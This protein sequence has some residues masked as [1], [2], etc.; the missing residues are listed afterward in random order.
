MST[1]THLKI[2]KRIQANSEISQRQL[3]QELGVSVGKVNYCLRALIDKGFVKAGNF[4]RSPNK[5][6]Y[7]Y[8]LTPTGIEEKASLTTRFLKRKIAEHEQITQEIE[9]LKRDVQSI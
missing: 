5:M 7:L 4:K 2:L 8:L 3:A 1:E 6:A 9:Q